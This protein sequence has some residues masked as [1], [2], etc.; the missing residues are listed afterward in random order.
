VTID[1]CTVQTVQ[2]S[3]EIGLVADVYR[4]VIGAFIF[5]EI[6]FQFDGLYVFAGTESLDSEMRHPLF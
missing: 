5:Y 2:L 3:I 4:L 1:N 6:A